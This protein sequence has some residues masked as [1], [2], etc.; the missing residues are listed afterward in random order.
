M[1][2]SAA[3]V[4][5]TGT[6]ITSSSDEPGGVT[7]SMVLRSDG[8]AGVL[9]RCRHDAGSTAAARSA[10]A[11]HAEATISMTAATV[12]DSTAAANATA[13]SVS[14]V[15]MPAVRL[16][17]IRS[18]PLDSPGATLAPSGASALFPTAQDHHCVFAVYGAFDVQHDGSIDEVFFNPNGV[19]RACA[20]GSDASVWST[21]RRLGWT[22]PKN[23]TQGMAM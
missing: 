10:A 4:P 22:L 20:N 15:N 23:I 3:A 8:V 11:P 7:A 2:P 1:A 13:A 14:I 18:I 9:L 21:S 5:L 12:M 16:Q 19:S 17:V 6:R